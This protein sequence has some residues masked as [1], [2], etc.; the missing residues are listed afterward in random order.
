MNRIPL[1]GKYSHKFILVDDCDLWISEYRWYW[2]PTGYP[3]SVINGKNVRAHTI[4][5]KA[6]IGLMAD[7]INGD[8]LDCR[9][10]NLRI[11]SP[12]QNAMN[13]S[14]VPGSTSK[15]KG[16]CWSSA[17]GRWRAQISV[18]Y[19]QVYLGLFDTEVDAAAAYNST[20]VKFYGEYSRLNVLP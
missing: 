10:S 7:H 13:R 4:I 11:C 16:V 8:R 6:P 18:K 5:A 12:S 17:A 1:A 14:G 19:R 15:Y 2:C 9:R 3:S 20:A